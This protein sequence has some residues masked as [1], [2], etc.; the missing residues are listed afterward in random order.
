MLRTISLLLALVLATIGAGTLVRSSTL[1]ASNHSAVR[2][3]SQPWAMPGGRLVVTITATG[4]GGF[5]Q[6]EETLPEGFSYTGSSLSEGSVTVYGQTVSFVLLGDGSFTY[7]VQ[8]PDMEDTYTFTGVLK[9][10]NREERVIGGASQV[11]VGPEPT[12][13]PTPEPTA[14]PTPTIEPSATATPEPTIAPTSAPEPTEAPAVE[15]MATATP[16]PEPTA[17]SAPEPTSSQTRTPAPTATTAPAAAAATAAQ[18]PTPETDVAVETSGPGNF[19][20]AAAAV[21]LLAVGFFAG[22]LIGS[23]KSA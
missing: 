9:D 21:L 12:A 23:R 20:M 8:V 11:L 4:Y 3:F 17:T 2:S 7:T 13:T 14:T 22:Y 6:V 5:G 18:S 1:E 16:E 10:A 15:S 19:A